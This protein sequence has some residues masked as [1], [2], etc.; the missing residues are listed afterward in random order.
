MLQIPFA[1]LA[2]EQMHAMAATCQKFHHELGQE[3][4][5]ARALMGAAGRLL[6]RQTRE[7]K[8]VKKAQAK[9]QKLDKKQPEH[10]TARNMYMMEL[11]AGVAQMGHPSNLRM[12]KSIQPCPRGPSD[13]L[14][15]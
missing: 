1:T 9:L 2:A 12:V 3:L 11:S 14:D 7:E 6:P 15:V 4:L 8:A 5:I 13:V 10:I